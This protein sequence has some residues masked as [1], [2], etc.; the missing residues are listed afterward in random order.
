M[1]IIY[2]SVNGLVAG[3]CE[4]INVSLLLLPQSPIIYMGENLNSTLLSYIN[5]FIPI[6]TMLN[7]TTAWC[8]CMAT[9]Y[10]VSVALRWAKAIE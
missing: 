10:I 1:G 7:I 4:L 5:W 2:G 3:F 6:G 8:G 9:W